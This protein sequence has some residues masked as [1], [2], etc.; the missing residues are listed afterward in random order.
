MAKPKYKTI[1]ELRAARVRSSQKY[2]EAHRS[3]RLEYAREYYKRK[4]AAAKEG[5]A[6]E[7]A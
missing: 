2:Y 3:E 6:D 5:E 1:E 7:K 4:K